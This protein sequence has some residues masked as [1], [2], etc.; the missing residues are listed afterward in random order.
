MGILHSC[1]SKKN[2]VG[3]ISEEEEAAYKKIEREADLQLLEDKETPHRVGFETVAQICEISSMDQCA[4]GC[5][6]GEGRSGI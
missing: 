6:Q 4:D 3:V 1:F 5:R 2:K